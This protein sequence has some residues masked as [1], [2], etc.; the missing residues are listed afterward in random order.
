MMCA[1]LESRVGQGTIAFI[2]ISNNFHPRQHVVQSTHLDKGAK[3]FTSGKLN[4][5]FLFVQHQTAKKGSILYR[6][7]RIFTTG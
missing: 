1:A 7:C 6:K 3:V 2:K 4:N 5:L